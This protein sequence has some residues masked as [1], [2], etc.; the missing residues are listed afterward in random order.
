MNTLDPKAP[1]GHCTGCTDPRSEGTH[2]EGTIE[3][4]MMDRRERLLSAHEMMMG[5]M[6]AMDVAD[7]YESLITKGVLRVVKT[8][9]IKDLEELAPS[10][11]G[12]RSWYHKTCTAKGFH[13]MKG[14]LPP[15]CPG[16]G[17]EIQKP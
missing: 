3:H 5:N 8:I 13:P 11:T 15:F 14:G 12:A 6:Q 10:S 7:H 16:C 9:T 2:Q 17:G 4:P 1:Y